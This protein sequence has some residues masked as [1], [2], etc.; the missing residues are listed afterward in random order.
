MK[1]LFVLLLTASV[2]F[3]SF[4]VIDKSIKTISV[5]REQSVDVIPGSS[6]YL[7]KDNH[8]NTVLSWVKQL[9][10]STA[11]LCYSILDGQNKT[12]EIPS[13]KNINAHAENLPKII[14][15]YSGDII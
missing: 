7:T 14:F 10:D 1:H 2:V 5:S 3:I 13:S 9:S 8:G 4:T 15:K 6:P 11:V 12:F